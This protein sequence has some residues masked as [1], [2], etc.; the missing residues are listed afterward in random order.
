[1]KRSERVEERKTKQR[2]ERD[3]GVHGEGRQITAEDENEV[4][5][6]KERWRQRRQNRENK[7]NERTEAPV[8]Y[9]S[10]SSL[11]CLGPLG[12]MVEQ[13]L[14]SLFNDPTADLMTPA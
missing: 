10:S 6:S 2:R 12:Q 11:Y 13:T 4:E 9:G 14:I 8:A 7:Q 3:G 5:R 1:M